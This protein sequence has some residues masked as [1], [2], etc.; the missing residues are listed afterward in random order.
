MRGRGLKN[1][2][3]LNTMTI[4]TSTYLRQMGL[5]LVE[6]LIT[7][8]VAILLLGTALPDIKHYFERARLRGATEAVRSHLA[9]ARSEAIKQ[10]R[11]IV[12]RYEMGSGVGWS[13]VSQ[14]QDSAEALGTLQGSEF[15]GI[16]A[17]ANRPATRFDGRIG[18]AFGS[19]VTIRLQSPA[20]L[21]TRVIV[22]NTGRIRTC[23]PAGAGNV[24]GFVAC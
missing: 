23:S 6:L 7:L 3:Q 18:A 17:Q 8:A 2:M 22:A 1:A 13:L 10:S 20:G 19:N 21:E 15:P 16:S 9:L 14:T 11:A 5:S 24:G 4:M 12:V